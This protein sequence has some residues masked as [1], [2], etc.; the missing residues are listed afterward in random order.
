MCTSQMTADGLTP[1]SATLERCSNQPNRSR[2]YHK[3]EPISI[4]L[5]KQGDKVVLGWDIDTVRQLLK[6]PQKLKIKVCEALLA[7]TIAA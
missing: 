4:K 7:I 6:L 1:V 2:K 5:P 3:K